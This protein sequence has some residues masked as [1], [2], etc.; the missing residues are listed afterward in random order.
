LLEEL[1][2]ELEAVALKNGHEMTAAAD[3]APRFVVHLSMEDVTIV[4]GYF[5][6]E[7][8]GGALLTVELQT[9]YL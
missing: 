1:L 7:G 6:L 9:K 3:V 2:E 4:S 5:D 8:E